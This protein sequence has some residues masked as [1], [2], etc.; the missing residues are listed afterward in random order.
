MQILPEK[1]CTLNR[2][3]FS[4]AEQVRSYFCVAEREWGL[5]KQVLFKAW[6]LCSQW[7]TWTVL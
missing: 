3:S 4:C 1:Y 7:N 2:R 5:T 6:D